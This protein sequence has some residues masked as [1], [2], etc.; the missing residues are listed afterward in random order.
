MAVTAGGVSIQKQKILF[1]QISTDTPPVV[2]ATVAAVGAYSDKGFVAQC[3]NAPLSFLS[4]PQHKKNSTLGP[5]RCNQFY[6]N[7][8]I[9]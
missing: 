6:G 7:Q 9:P 1:L 5:K 2:R 4:R 3:H 8:S